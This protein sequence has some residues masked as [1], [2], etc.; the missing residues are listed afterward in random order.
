MKKQKVM[1]TV[2]AMGFA[3]SMTVSVYAA[4]GEGLKIVWVDGNQANESNAVCADAA[5]AYAEEQ[6]VGFSILDG[7]GSGETQ[8]SQVETAISQGV[9]AIIVQPY[10]AAA[11]P[12]WR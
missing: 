1:A 11:L 4:D 3:L 2:A 10:D 7:Q 9:D 5:K 8:V 6:G 12:G